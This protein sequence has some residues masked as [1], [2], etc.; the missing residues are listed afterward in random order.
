MK[1]FIIFAWFLIFH[2]ILIYAQYIPTQEDLLINDIYPSPDDT[3]Q[4]S[5]KSSPIYS[6]YNDFRNWIPYM[7]SEPLKNPPITYIEVSFHVFLDNDWGNN[8]YTNNQEGKDK[9]LYQIN[10]VNSIYSGGW[11]PS[12]PVAGVVELPNRDTRIRFTLGDNNERIYFYNNTTQN[13]HWNSGSFYKYVQDSFPDR[14]NKL[15]VFFTAGLY[16]G[17]VE[18]R[19]IEITNAGSGYTSP[20][21]ISFSSLGTWRSATAHAIIDNGR[22]TSISLV[23]GGE[24]NG[25]KPPIITIT[26]GGGIGA[27]AVVTELSGGATG[28]ANMPDLDL[29]STSH[30]V[31]LASHKE[32]SDWVRGMVLAHEFGH[33]LDLFHTYCGGGASAKICNNYCSLFACDTDP[34]TCNSN[35]YL[36][37][38]FGPCPGT[39]PHVTG[40]HDPFLSGPQHTNNMMGGSSAQLY[41]SPMQAG[42]MHRALAL[43][44]VRKYVK[45]ET[46]SNVPLVLNNSETWDFNLKLYRDIIIASSNVLTIKNNFELTDQAKISILKDSQVKVD[47]TA[48]LKSNNTFIIERGG[49]LIVNGTLDMGKQGKIVIKP[50]AKLTVN[51]GNV[52]GG[53]IT[54]SSEPWSGIFVEGDRTK[55]QTFANQGANQP[56]GKHSK[57]V[58]RAC[59]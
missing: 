1:K 15:N 18:Q 52:N 49:E 2:S 38:I 36:S 24:Y 26:G 4:P 58:Q 35:E 39:Y 8:V 14:V 53:K 31:M 22:I 5:L 44:S 42:Q 28:Y 20:P 25:F 17:R 54:S 29:S 56:S 50:G 32:S 33:N 55:S 47:G 30:V 43:K 23:H 10:L 40:W 11:G 51:G 45:N 37:D 59:F 46:F 41:I 48:I 16:K 57:F 34:E 6:F 19:N 13:H 27:T 12:D 3:P 9:L 7:N 21:T